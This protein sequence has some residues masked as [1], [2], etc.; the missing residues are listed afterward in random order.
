MNRRNFIQALGLSPLVALFAK[1]AAAEPPAPA[2]SDP[3]RYQSPG[4]PP[5]LVVPG[6]TYRGIAARIEQAA[7]QT[8]A[9]YARVAE[10]WKLLSGV[11]RRVYP[12]DIHDML[13]WGTPS[14]LPGRS[15]AKWHWVDNPAPTGRE[16]HVPRDYTPSQAYA[17]CQPGDRIV[18]EPRHRRHP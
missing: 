7:K 15:L 5:E 3:R 6:K 9:Y 18:I 4:R 11:D 2:P 14:S 13:H 8:D 10:D 1:T 17:L 12:E 16:L